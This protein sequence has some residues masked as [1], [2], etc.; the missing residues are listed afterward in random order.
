M[1]FLLCGIRLSLPRDLKQRRQVL[2]MGFLVWIT[3][4]ISTFEI[5]FLFWSVLWTAGTALVLMQQAWEGSA[6]LREGLLARAPVRKVAGWTLGTVLISTIFFAGLPRVTLGLRSFPWGVAGL[7][8]TQAGLSDSLDLGGE[9]PIAANHDLVLRIIPPG[10]AGDRWGPRLAL[11]KGLVLESLEGQRWTTA[12]DTPPHDPSGTGTGSS[13]GALT[14]DYFVAPS[15]SGVIPFPYGRLAIDPPEGMPLRPGP[16]GSLR[17][18]YPT[19]RPMPLR[20]ALEPSSLPSEPAPVGARRALLVARGQGTESADVYSR[21]VVPG[22]VPARELA[23]RLTRSL[24]AFHYTLL[25]PSGGA[26]NPLQDF[27]ERTRAGHCEYFAS[28]LALMLRYRGVPARVVNGYRLG[29]WIAEGGYW[30]VTQNEAHSWVEYYDEA[31]GTWRVADPTPAAPPGGLAA[32]TFWAA[33]QRWTDAVR[34]RWDRH[35]VRFSDQDQLAGFTWAQARL[36]A[37][38][39]WRPDRRTW[40]AA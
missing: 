26:R 25:N 10:G 32:D 37:L 30:I 28:A 18:R 23:E 3:T 24:H 15:P 31:D 7:T 34:F 11:L 36:L 16:G 19:R 21:T 20:F 5:D 40:L 39:E 4:A 17:W 6:S 22:E 35:V 8:G 27:L 1:L 13:G 33:F 2:L 29:P 14:L 12:P 9:G 38:P